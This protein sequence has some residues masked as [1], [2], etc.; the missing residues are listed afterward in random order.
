MGQDSSRISYPTRDAPPHLLPTYPAA[1]ITREMAQNNSHFS[2]YDR[3]PRQGTGYISSRMNGPLDTTTIDRSTALNRQE[4]RMA[5]DRPAHPGSRKRSRNDVWDGPLEEE[6][7]VQRARTGSS[8]SLHQ[9]GPEHVITSQTFQDALNYLR[10]GRGSMTAIRGRKFRYRSGGRTMHR[11]EQERISSAFANI[12]PPG[13]WPPVNSLAGANHT[14]Q[15]SIT[16]SLHAPNLRKRSREEDSDADS[17]ES[18]GERHTKLRRR[19]EEQTPVGRRASPNVRAAASRPGTSHR[20]PNHSMRMN[21]QSQIAHEDES[22]SLD[23]T[24]AIENHNLE[25]ASSPAPDELPAAEALSNQDH[26]SNTSRVVIDLTLDDTDTEE[27]ASHQATSDGREF[28]WDFP[29]DSDTEHNVDGPRSPVFEPAIPSG[30]QTPRSPSL[31]GGSPEPAGPTS[32]QMPGSEE[33]QPEPT[34]PQWETPS[35]SPPSSGFD[36]TDAGNDVTD[37][38]YIGDRV[39]AVEE[40]RLRP[41]EQKPHSNFGM[42]LEVVENLPMYVLSRKPV[43]QASRR[44]AEEYLM[45]GAHGDLHKVTIANEP[46]C[47]CSEGAHGLPCWHVLFVS[48]LFFASN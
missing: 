2:P 6:R 28:L 4:A 24:N 8:S 46:R 20:F 21:P 14:V 16:P 12:D 22:Q 23:I 9:G 7:Q 13:R 17:E 37:W 45:V 43:T 40:R 30:Q 25:A 15:P 5:E 48:F 35:S 32:P 41:F 10:S 38:A 29:S 31:R 33:P 36:Y 18:D 34:S 19:G 27:E 44:I 3:Q 11:R 42:F 47:D 26:Q 1:N 39:L